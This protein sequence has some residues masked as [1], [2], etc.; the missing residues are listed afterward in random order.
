MA[1]NAR[2]LGERGGLGALR[3]ELPQSV[4][5][6]RR[7]QAYTPTAIL[8]SRLLYDVYPNIYLFIMKRKP[9]KH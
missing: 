6:S 9:T 5:G 4:V 7:L 8:Q 3:P 1:H 2:R